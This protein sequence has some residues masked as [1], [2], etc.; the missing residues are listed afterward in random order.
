MWKS[1]KKSGFTREDIR[2]QTY[3]TSPST[4]TLLRIATLY[5]EG[6]PTKAIVDVTGL[7]RNTVNRLRET[8]FSSRLQEKIEEIRRAELKKYMT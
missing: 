5:L 7:A 1:M 6:K 8:R 2:E 4:Y 3:K